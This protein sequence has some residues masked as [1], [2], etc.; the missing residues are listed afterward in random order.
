[1]K[2]IIV[3]IAIISSII[4]SMDSNN[5]H[6]TYLAKVE[7]P[8]RGSDKDDS[9]LTV[10]Y[11]C[12]LTKTDFFKLRKDKWEK[13][14]PY[15]IALIFTDHHGLLKTTY[16]DA[17]TLNKKI[18]ISYN[19]F[20]NQ[21]QKPKINKPLFSPINKKEIIKI[22]YFITLKEFNKLVYLTTLDQLLEDKI[23]R[24]M[25]GIFACQNPKY[26]YRNLPIQSLLRF[27]KLNVIDLSTDQLINI[28]Q[29]IEITHKQ[30]CKLIHALFNRSQSDYNKLLP[31][32]SKSIIYRT[33]IAYRLETKIINL[34]E[35][36]FEQTKDEP[37]IRLINVCFYFLYTKH[38]SNKF[39][40][41]KE[42]KEYIIKKI[43]SKPIS[44]ETFI[45]LI[46]HIF[47]SFKDDCCLKN[48]I[49]ICL[50]TLYPYSQKYDFESYFDSN[51]GSDS[52]SFDEKQISSEIS[53]DL[54]I[55][56]R[57]F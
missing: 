47:I 36:L 51:S 46:N 25:H 9:D 20:I 18:F 34:I 24:G 55:E 11:Q 21:K 14:R 27:Y 30:F 50:Y 16:V 31:I 19:K 49:K 37:L 32:I 56:S 3:C 22:E 39:P 48:L 33:D 28:C 52:S 29:K 26:N 38:R 43:N 7:H 40:T 45:K 15:I 2:K 5:F 12:P 6:S 44:K 41:S 4:H 57:S 35:N 13:K 53:D 17:H 8:F 42:K 23:P 10:L 54:D 1:M